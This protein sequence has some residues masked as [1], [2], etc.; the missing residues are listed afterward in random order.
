M[1]DE[2]YRFLKRWIQ[3]TKDVDILDFLARQAV[4]NNAY[5]LK[6]LADYRKRMIEFNFESEEL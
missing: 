2:G 6:I 5:E 3:N 1:T 4:K